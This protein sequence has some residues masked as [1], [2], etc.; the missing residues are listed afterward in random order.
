MFK[1]IAFRLVF[2]IYIKFNCFSPSSTLYTASFTIKQPSLR[3]GLGGLE[4]TRLE[5]QSS[6]L[7]QSEHQVHVLHSLSYGT[8]Q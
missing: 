4:R 5:H 8:L 6:L 3:E 7:V 1:S 2:K